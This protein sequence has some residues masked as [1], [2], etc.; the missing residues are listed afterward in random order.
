MKIQYLKKDNR[1]EFKISTSNSIGRIKLALFS[2]NTRQLIMSAKQKQTE[3]RK[4]KM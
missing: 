2:L 4:G 1:E 3:L